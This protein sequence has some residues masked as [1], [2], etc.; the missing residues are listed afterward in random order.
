[1]AGQQARHVVLRLTARAGLL[2]FRQPQVAAIDLR[3]IA[4]P[5]S[6]VQCSRDNAIVRERSLAGQQPW[7]LDAFGS[8]AD[9]LWP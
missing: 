2:S 8:R 7:I 4:V 6:N 5:E 3:A 1:M 9:V